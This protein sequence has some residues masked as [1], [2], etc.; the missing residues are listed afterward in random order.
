MVMFVV[1]NFHASSDALLF[2]AIMLKGAETHCMSNTV[3]Y[4]VQSSL[5]RVHI[6]GKFINTYHVSL[7]AGDVTDTATK[8]E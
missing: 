4:T 8:Q 2:L 6:F 1:P 7:I 5:K 3:L